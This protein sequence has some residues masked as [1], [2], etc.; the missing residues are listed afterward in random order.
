MYDSGSKL[1]ILWVIALPL[2]PLVG[3]LVQKLWRKFDPDRR[4]PLLAL[5][6]V[7]LTA[8]LFTLFTR[9]SFRG[10]WPQAANLTLAYISAACFLVIVFTKSR[11]SFYLFAL[12]GFAVFVFVLLCYGLA[13]AY[14]RTDLPEKETRLGDHLILRQASGGWAVSIGKV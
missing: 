14:L 9:W 10:L 3:W 8:G 12:R 2:G 7:S 13:D 4:R 1:W 5:F 6:A 11:K